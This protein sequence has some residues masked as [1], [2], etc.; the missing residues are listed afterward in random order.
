MSNKYAHLLLLV[1]PS[2]PRNV[3]LTFV[4]QSTV[5]IR[6]LPPV[7]TGDQTHVHYDFGC[8]KQCNSNKNCLEEYCERGVNYI[9]YKEGLNATQVT[10]ADLSPLAITVSKST[11]RTE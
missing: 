8:R 3:T 10:V 2:A 5:E 1:L 7:I 6:W 4:D 9:P 11:L